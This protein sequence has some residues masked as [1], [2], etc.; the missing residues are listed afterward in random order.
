M[1]TQLEPLFARLQ[2]QFAFGS[3]DEIVQRMEFLEEQQVQAS[4]EISAT[5]EHNAV[6]K[7]RARGEVGVVFVGFAYT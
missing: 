1:F 3:P 7:V 5:Q 4:E 2:E 6:L